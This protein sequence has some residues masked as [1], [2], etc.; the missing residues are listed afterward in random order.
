[1]PPIYVGM[2]Q[3]ERKVHPC[4]LWQIKL[5]CCMKT[6][7]LILSFT[8][9][10]FHSPNILAKN[11]KGAEY[12]TKESFLY[13]RFEASFKACGKEGTLST[14]FT[15]FDGTPTD[16]WAA[17]KWNEIDIEILGRYSNDVQFNTITSGATNHVRH[18]PVNFDPALDYHTYAFEWTPDYIAWFIDGVEV[19]RQ[20]EAFVK[21][22]IRPQKFMF[23]TWI[24][25]WADWVGVFTEQILPAF[26]YYDWA[27]YYSYTP[28]KGNYGTQNNFTFSWRDDFDAFDS[29]R[30][31]KATHTWSGNNSDMAPENINFKDGK[32]ILSLT[33]AAEMGMNDR[34]AP[35]IITARAINE[36]KIQVFF[37]ELI[38]KIS[39]EDPAKFVIPNTA[40]VK[41]AVLLSN[42][43]T[44]E[45][46]VEQLDLSSLSNIIV[47]SGIKDKANPPNSSGLMSRTL[48]ATPKFKFPVKINVGGEATNNFLADREFRTDTASYGY[49]EGSK[50]SAVSVTGSSEN[51][52]YQTGII[53]LTKYAVRVP[54]GKYSI[55]L[56]FAEYTVKNVNE[57]VFDVY[58]QGKQVIK[59]LDIYKEAGNLKALEKVIEDVIVSD[60]FLDV[61]FAALVGNTVLNG[62]IIESIGTSVD[63]QSS[64]PNV[65]KLEQNYPNPFNPTTAIS[66]KLQA[67]S[68]VTLKVYDVLGR[69]VAMLVDEYK[70]AGTYI[71][72]FDTHHAELSRSIPSGV[73]FYRIS[74]GD[75]TAVR[76]MI[77]LK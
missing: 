36:S 69:E 77:L 49:M 19:Y 32:M 68:H 30:W 2:Q 76:K 5:W 57:R 18:Q 62:I 52:V 63:Q 24:P 50:I 55:K 34:K 35:T 54:N 6:S 47:Y 75:Y 9:F 33:T 22:V 38:D 11:Y 39:A 31:A 23:N 46:D 13:G 60:Y 71:T 65:F 48:I 59:A 14:M 53:G 28:G 66:Y 58:T 27:A 21:T 17:H 41:K 64:L 72:T 74:A 67:A 25:Q 37:S 70:Q 4:C 7:I 45:L 12:R 16:P 20:T 42:Q 8:F 29:N 51:I 44:V 43:R 15:Y 56:L 26:T 61:H 73:Y 1:M 10:L 3:G 40:P